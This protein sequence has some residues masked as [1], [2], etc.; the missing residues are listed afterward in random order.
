[1]DPADISPLTVLNSQS[2][3]II[4]SQRPNQAT[5]A[6]N[7]TAKLCSTNSKIDS[8]KI[9]NGEQFNNSILETEEICQ[10]LY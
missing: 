1:M 3:S 5:A 10:V 9:A 2:H 4:E 6:P 7:H 8:I